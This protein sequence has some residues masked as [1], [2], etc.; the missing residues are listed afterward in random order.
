MNASWL[1]DGCGCILWLSS[2]CLAV[3]RWKRCRVVGVV[4]SGRGHGKLSLESNY[5]LLRRAV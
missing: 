2:E 1:K 3:C 5:S 4:Q